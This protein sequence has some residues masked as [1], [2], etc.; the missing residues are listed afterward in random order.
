MACHVEFHAVA[1]LHFKGDVVAGRGMMVVM[2]PCAVVMGNICPFGNDGGG[3]GQARGLIVFVP[4]LEGFD[5][6]DED[7]DAHQ[8]RDQCARRLRLLR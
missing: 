4:L 5:D 1:A 8:R 7:K 2:F 3:D 6:G